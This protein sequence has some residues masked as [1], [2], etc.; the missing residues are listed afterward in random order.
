MSAC[1]V[2]P[3]LVQVGYIARPLGALIFGHIGKPTAGT[4]G[5]LKFKGQQY[6][7]THEHTNM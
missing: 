6:H 1:C 3:V 5:D 7:S 2:L 4:E